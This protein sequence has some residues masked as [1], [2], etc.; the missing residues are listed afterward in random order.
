MGRNLVF[1]VSQ[2]FAG[3]AAYNEKSMRLRL[4]RRALLSGA[5][6]KCRVIVIL[7]VFRARAGC[8]RPVA[9]HSGS[10]VV[11]LLSLCRYPHT[12]RR[13]AVQPAKISFPLD[14]YIA[15]ASSRV[16]SHTSTAVA[17]PPE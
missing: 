10:A 4:Q 17:W 9:R 13:P 15:P 12:Q 7:T 5:I 8:I 14:R 1:R 2:Q 16:I 11:F 6:E 3:Y